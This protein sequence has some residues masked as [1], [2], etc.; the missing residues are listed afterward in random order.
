MKIKS[1]LIPSIIL[2]IIG[3]TLKVLNINWLPT[4]LLLLGLLGLLF[5]L[6]L[7]VYRKLK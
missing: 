3:A 6:I 5:S 1:F 4:P 2:V 7:F